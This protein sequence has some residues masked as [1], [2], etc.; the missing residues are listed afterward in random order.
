MDAEKSKNRDDCNHDW[1]IMREAGPRVGD[2]QGGEMYPAVCQCKKYALIMTASEAYQLT[3]VKNQSEELQH[4]KT[5]QKKIAIITI[6]ISLGALA[7]S[8][9]ALFT[10]N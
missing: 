6:L 7:I 10:K 8:I 3:A 4:L 9:I 1:S 5:F 2:G